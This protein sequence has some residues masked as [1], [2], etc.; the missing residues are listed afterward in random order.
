[1]CTTPCEADIAISVFD[2]EGSRLIEVKWPVPGLPVG[3]IGSQG[4]EGL[5]TL[6]WL[7]FFRKE[8]KEAEPSKVPTSP[9]SLKL[10]GTIGRHFHTASFLGPRSPIADPGPLGH[11][12]SG[13]GKSWEGWRSSILVP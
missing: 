13:I 7:I 8:Q 4:P 3:Q 12:A 11:D 9:D 6:P 10:P 1:M 5:E 2:R